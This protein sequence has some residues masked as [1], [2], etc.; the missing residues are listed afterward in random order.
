[1]S[2]LKQ[3]ANITVE[4]RIIPQANHVYSKH[5]DIM[6]HEISSYIKAHPIEAPV[7]SLSKA[8][9]A[10]IRAKVRTM[11]PGLHTRSGPPNRAREAA[12][13]SPINRSQS[14]GR[15]RPRKSPA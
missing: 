4:H 8:R 14:R 1:M 15:G 10:A 13:S 6:G 5:L 7:V 3:Q 12:S 9:Q 2:I 11:G